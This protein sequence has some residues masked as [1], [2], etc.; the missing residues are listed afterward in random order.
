MYIVSIG[1]IFLKGK[2]RNIF[3]RRLM[4]NMRLALDLDPNDIQRHR[5]RYIILKEENINKLQ[6]VFGVYSYSKAIKCDLEKIDEIALSFIGNEKTFRISSKKLHSLNKSSTE[7]NEEIGSYI[8]EHKPRIKVDL[9]NPEINIRIE[10]ISKKA[11]LY[12]E[13]IKGPGGL[14]TGSSGFVFMRVNDEVRSTVAAYLIMKRGCAVAL[15]KDLPLVHKFEHGFTIN[16]RDERE[17]DFVVAD[18]I[19]EDLELKEENKFIMKPLIGYTDKQI[20]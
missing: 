2:N 17:D 10:E 15:S 19:F 16:I 8:I 14:P 3:E 13:I 20:K 1:E 7:S 4:K 6:R 11:Y 12:T 18:E 5:N 9:E